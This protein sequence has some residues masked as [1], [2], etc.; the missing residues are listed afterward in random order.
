MVASLLP[1]SAGRGSAWLA[2]ERELDLCVQRLRTLGPTRVEPVAAAARA[3]AQRLA[4]LAAA[5]EGRPA[6]RA[7][8]ALAP[9]ALADQVAVTGADLLAALGRLD[10]DARATEALAGAAAAAIADLRRTLP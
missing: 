5:A 3:L 10:P 4:D 9:A 7:V 2:T 1:V 8:P 6:D